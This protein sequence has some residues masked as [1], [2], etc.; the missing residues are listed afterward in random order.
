MEFEPVI[1]LEVH[2]QLLTKS[3]LFCACST[4]FGDPPN[5]NICPVCTGQAGALPVLNKE[6]VVMAI[7]AGLSLHCEIQEKSIFAR[8]NYF[9][10]DLPKGYQISQY[11][12]PIC[13]S[14]KLEIAVDGKAKTIT[15]Q[16]IHMEEDAGKLLHEGGHPDE[17]NID[18]NRCSTPLIEIVSGPDLDNPKEAV[19]YLKKLRNILVYLGVCDGNMQEG[20]LRCDANISVRP[21]GSKKLGTRTEIK[22]VNSFKYIE[23]ALNYEIKRQ[24]EVIESG[25]KIVQE[26]RLY[27]QEKNTT[28]TMRSKEEAHDYRYFPDP[29]LLP[30]I[31]DKKWVETVAKSLPELAEEKAARFTQSFK[32]PEYDAKVLTAE[33]PLADYFEECV[34]LYDAPKKLS[35]WIMAELMREL[36]ERDID[37]TAI[38][39]KPKQLAEMVQLIDEGTISGAIAKKVFMEVLDSGKDPE[40]IIEEKGWKQVSDTSAIEPIID[41]ILAN[42]QENVER[43]KSGKTNVLGFFVGAVMK[44]TKGQANPQIINELLKKKLDQK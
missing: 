29:D 24:I 30:L 6:A 9:Y 13:L 32:I 40:K 19:E 36:K 8:K 16:R 15:I 37:V 35:N 4:K 39:M 27:N 33:K 10:P 26:T 3:K 7:K 2:A 34:K 12:F 5:T 25:G 31:V 20:S 43:Y 22:N 38:Q 14:G 18:L 42:N 11:E 44:E 17:S 21:K 28:E 1:G 23:N 41:K